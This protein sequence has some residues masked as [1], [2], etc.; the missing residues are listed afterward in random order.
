[1]SILWYLPP[2][3]VLIFIIYY[4]FAVK[5]SISRPAEFVRLFIAAGLIVAALGLFLWVT[6]AGFDCSV[7]ISM[8]ATLAATIV[9]LLKDPGSALRNI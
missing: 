3:V 6:L 1:M 7:R 8:G 2:L 4:N 5:R 9:F